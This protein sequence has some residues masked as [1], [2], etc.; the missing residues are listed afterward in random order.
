MAKTTKTRGDYREEVAAALCGPEKPQ[1]LA[2]IAEKLGFHPSTVSLAARQLVQEGKARK[3]A[4]GY[5]LMPKV[6]F[7]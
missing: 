7:L 4:E 3:C 1:K 5:Y 6:R 2:R